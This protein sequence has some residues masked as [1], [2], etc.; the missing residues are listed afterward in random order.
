MF[1]E[2]RKVKGGRLERMIAKAMNVIY[3]DE[4]DHYQEAAKEAARSIR[5]ARDL[6]RVQHLIRAVSMQRVLMRNEMFGQLMTSR[7]ITRC[8]SKAVKRLKR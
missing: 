1:R 8:L 2:G 5:N 4:K 3:R 6:K 7:Q